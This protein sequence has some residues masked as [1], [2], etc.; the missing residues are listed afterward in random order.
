MG[1]RMAQTSGLRF[2][3][4]QEARR[5]RGAGPQDWLIPDVTPIGGWLALG[6]LLM[7]PLESVSST[8]EG[9]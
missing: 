4:V 2:H 5:S 7:V 8:W 9:C 1:N 6:E 3:L